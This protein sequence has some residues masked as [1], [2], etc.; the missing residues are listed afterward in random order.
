[1][2]TYPC[3]L[4]EVVIDATNN[5]IAIDDGGFTGAATVAAGSYFLRGDGE[6]DDLALA[7]QTAMN[8]YDA[9]TYA[10][11]VAPRAE[12]ALATV[13][14]TRTAGAADFA[15]A[16]ADGGNT[17]DLAL[18]GLPASTSSP[19]AGVITST[20][21]PSGLWVG[22]EPAARSDPTFEGISRQVR[23]TAGQVRTFDRGGPYALRELE[24]Q[25]ADA[26]RTL[27]EATPT[28]EARAF[29]SFWRLVRDGRAVELHELEVASSPVLEAT[30]ADDTLVGTFV[31]DEA[32]C[33]AFRPRRFE[34]GVA[35]YGW[36]LGLRGYAA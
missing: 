10:V 23:M 12:G 14:I 13:T 1:M 11:A 21:S 2:T 20:L 34:P 4:A 6:A 16:G 7:I 31:F 30:D 36:T 29:E 9:N 8:A 32:T 19:T 26:E 15:I 28:D 17:F 5:A 27:I 33:A 3:L 25:F 35:L 22:N 18:I 24:M